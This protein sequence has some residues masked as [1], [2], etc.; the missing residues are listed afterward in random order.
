MSNRRANPTRDYWRGRQVV[1]RCYDAD[2][3]LLYVGVSGDVCERLAQHRRAST[4]FKDTARTVLK[5][6]PRRLD[7]SRAELAAI[8]SERP[9]HNI[10]H[11]PGWV[12][13][14]WARRKGA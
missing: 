1:Y 14:R 8:R 9:L 7:A 11:A 5:V 10:R 6:Y 4:W 13:P 3:V 2:E 12:E